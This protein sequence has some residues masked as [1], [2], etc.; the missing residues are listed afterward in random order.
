MRFAG[1]TRLGGYQKWTQQ[2]KVIF[3]S[4]N[5]NEFKQFLIHID[6]PQLRRLA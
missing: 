2:Q 4:R 3:I 1:D 6:F 5:S